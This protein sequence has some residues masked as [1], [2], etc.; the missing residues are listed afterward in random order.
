MTD[1]QTKAAIA[2]SVI[3]TLLLVVT[4]GPFFTIWSFNTL[5]GLEIPYTFKT[6]CAVL[7]LITLFHGI[8]IVI[9]SRN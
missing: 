8:R 7:W 4:A 2:L 1:Q 9:R 5:F 3:I 6:W